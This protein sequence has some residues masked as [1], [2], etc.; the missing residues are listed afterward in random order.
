M[1]YPEQLKKVHFIGIGGIGVS[2]IARLLAARGVAISGS[3][4]ALPPRALLPAGDFVE[5]HKKEHVPPDTTLV[6]YS[7]ASPET[8]PERLAAR[9]LNIPAYSYPEALAEV[10]KP[11]HTIAVSGT[12][13][14]STTTAL[15]GIF[16]ESGGLDPSVIVGAEVPGWKEK[17]LRI[18]MS[19]LFIVEACEYRRHMLLLTPQAIL[20]TNLELDH[21]D[22]YR[23]IDDM[24]DA[25]RAYVTKLSTAGLLIYNRDDANLRKIADESDAIKVSYGI[26]EGSD[27]YARNI[28]LVTG[29]QTFELVW[30]GTAFGEFFT[31]LYG[32]YNIYNILGATAI[33]LTY[34]GN[35]AS[36]REALAR[37]K[38]VGR[39]FE[40]VGNLGKSIVVS[41]YAHHPTAL[42]AVTK[43]A[44]DA[45]PGKEILVVFRPHQRERTIKLLNEFVA[46]LAEIDHALLVEIY[47]VAGREEGTL[48]SSRDLIAKL[49]AV[50]PNADIAYASD[51][52][53]AEAIIRENAAQFDV[54]LV[55]G[56]GDADQ[57]AWKLVTS[58]T[59]KYNNAHET[60]TPRVR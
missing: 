58:S 13:G 36:A 23:D 3:D 37:F 31:P 8:N 41:D 60:T 46:T 2:A 53:T 40:V 20:L 34:G 50:H 33:Y 52:N 54:I 15:A 39:R 4:I 55:V 59:Y 22:Y 12:H 17:N 14:K 28:R 18:G 27:L 5:G 32:L 16:F 44:R 26:G 57:L 9:E 25:F 43:A 38:G 49:L 1:F 24:M 51:L 45:F 7:A 10:T 48:I 29:G 56:A 35:I 19:D 47:D 6:V 21:P 11:Y 30:K 42:A